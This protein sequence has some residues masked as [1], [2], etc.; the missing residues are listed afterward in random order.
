MTSTA[1][2]WGAV[3]FLGEFGAPP[4]LDMLLPYMDTLYR[5]LDDAL[6][7]GTQWAYTPGWSAD[8]KDGWN[9]EDFSI[10]DDKGA[11]RDNFHPRPYARK[12][13]G[14]PTKL[15]VKGDDLTLEF[16]AGSG[17]TEIFAPKGSASGCSRQGD[18]LICKGGSPIRVRQ[19]QS[20]GLTGAEPLLILLVVGRMRRRPRRKAN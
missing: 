14:I 20:C 8:K 1:K 17:T 10:V 16:T 15:T 5:H 11:L 6:A 7:S 19:D 3:L 2:S 13:A 9:L 4:S 18:L 12:I